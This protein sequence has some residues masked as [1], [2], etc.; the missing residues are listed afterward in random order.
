[1]QGKVQYSTVRYGTIRIQQRG[2]VGTRTNDEVAPLCFGLRNVVIITV[3]DA[4]MMQVVCPLRHGTAHHSTAHQN[5]DGKHSKYNQGQTTLTMIS[6]SP[7]PPSGL[8]L[9]LERQSWSTTGKAR[10]ALPS[11]Y[12]YIWIGPCSPKP[13]TGNQVH[14]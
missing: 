9:P 7:P 12:P 13:N 10:Q 14:Q 3:S 1:M 2:K 8:I 5:Q 4:S 6:T 11:I